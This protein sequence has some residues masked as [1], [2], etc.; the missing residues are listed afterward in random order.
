MWGCSTDGIWY[1]QFSQ[2]EKLLCSLIQPMGLT[3]TDLDLFL[4]L[5]SSYSCL[6]FAVLMFPLQDPFNSSPLL[7]AA[8][9]PISIYCQCLLPKKQTK[10]PDRKVFCSKLD[11]TQNT[12]LQGH[13]TERNAQVF[14]PALAMLTKGS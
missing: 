12:I 9:L 5:L 13:K 6:T 11:W 10:V 1:M 3:W 2:H 4:C 7:V 14:Q 8:I